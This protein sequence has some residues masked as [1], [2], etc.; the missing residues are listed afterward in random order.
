LPVAKLP[1]V[2]GQLNMALA[3][4]LEISLLMSSPRAGIA[5]SVPTTAVW[6]SAK[7]GDNQASDP[8]PPVDPATDQQ[9]A[10]DQASAPSQ[11]PAA[12][13]P[14]CRDD[15]QPGSSA[16]SGCKPAAPTGS[17]TKK[18]HHKA[19][20]PAP[21]ESGPTKKVVTNGSAA[22]PTVDLSTGLSPQQA[23]HQKESTHQLLAASDANLK[24]I[25]AR[26][27]S[28]SQQDTVKQINSYMKQAEAAEKVGDVQRAHNL[29]VKANLLSADLVGP[30]K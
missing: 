22:D 25:A 2:A 20:A 1:Q 29:A 17:K 24:K 3:I 14:P 11:S 27:L 23:S 30:E 5:Y 28:P 6:Q 4:I 15:S 19:V 9:K 21:T 26:Q 18:H 10:A 8:S 7:A 13:S 12:A 16:K